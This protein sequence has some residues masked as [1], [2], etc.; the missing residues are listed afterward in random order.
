MTTC[1]N[2]KTPYDS[3]SKYC[4]S[5]GQKIS[6]DTLEERFEKNVEE[7]AQGME[8]IATSVGQSIAKNAKNIT[9][10]AGEKTRTM[11]QKVTK[12]SNDFQ[13][14][15]DKTFKFLG[16]LISSFI[17]VILFRLGLAV[18]ELSSAEW[19]KSSTIA[20]IILSYGLYLFLVIVVS[21]YTTYFAKKN[22]SFKIFSPVFHSICFILGLYIGAQ[23]LF[24]IS[25]ELSVATLDRIGTVIIQN[26]AP[27]FVFF[28]L[29][30]YVVLVLNMSKK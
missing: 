5:C 7:F 26:L 20:S 29:I 3:D 9:S 11:E 1:K 24:S 19:P 15:Y 30:N 27:L 21:N 17:F 8:Q 4:K 28:L 2:C 22:F 10:N 14:W 23:I 25:T 13:H 6:F 18:F 16:P 12:A